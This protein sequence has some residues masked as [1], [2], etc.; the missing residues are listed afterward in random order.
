MQKCL[1][2]C[3]EVAVLPST[4]NRLPHQEAGR[5]DFSILQPDQAIV[6]DTE[7]ADVIVLDGLRLGRFKSGRGILPL[8]LRQTVPGRGGVKRGGSLSQSLSLLYGPSLSNPLE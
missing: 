3:L 2:I 7:L 6:E 4:R 1:S 8:R 5:G